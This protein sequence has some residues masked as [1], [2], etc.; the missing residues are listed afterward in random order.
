MPLTD[1]R[2]TAFAMAMAA[3]SDVLPTDAAL[4]Q[5]AP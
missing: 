1:M 4:A 2:Q 3:L 5:A